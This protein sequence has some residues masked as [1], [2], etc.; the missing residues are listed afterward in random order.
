MSRLLQAVQWFALAGACA[1]GAEWVARREGF[2]EPPI[3]LRD[4]E[5]G[6][7]LA[8][9]RAYVRFGNTIRVNRYGFRSDDFDASSGFIPGTGVL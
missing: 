2:G 6:Y 7:Y 9:A 8:P 1:A 3:A 5:I 4:P